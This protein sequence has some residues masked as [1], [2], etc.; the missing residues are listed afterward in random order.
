MA[1]LEEVV[2]LEARVQ[3]PYKCPKC[4]QT[5]STLAQLQVR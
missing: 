4:P 2:E 5:F 3:K 1:D